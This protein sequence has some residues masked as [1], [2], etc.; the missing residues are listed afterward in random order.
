MP[1]M[2]A[3]MPMGVEVMILM[4]VEEVTIP[5]AVEEPTQRIITLLMTLFLQP[6]TSRTVVLILTTGCGIST[7]HV[8]TVLT[9]MIVNA[10][11]QQ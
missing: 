5:M 10:H 2:E 6:L 9:L 8:K 7:S 11:Q 3:T 4:L 1:V